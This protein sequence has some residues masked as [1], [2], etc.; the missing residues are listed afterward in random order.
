M[1]PPNPPVIEGT[2]WGIIDIE[3][4]FCI[5]ATDPNGDN[6]YCI[7]DW[8]DGNITSWIG[9]YSSGEPICASHNWSQKGTYEIRVKL[10]DIYGQESDWSDPYIITIYEL[11][12]TIIFGRYSNMTTENGFITIEA[13]NLWTIQSRPL[14]SNL[15]TA[16]EKLTFSDDYIGIKLKRFIIGASN[17]LH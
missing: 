13:V 9:P 14:K 7:W 10:K 16:P 11:K 17:I 15:H 1:A 4:T 12:K 2:T 8:G 6:L 3:Y 5:N